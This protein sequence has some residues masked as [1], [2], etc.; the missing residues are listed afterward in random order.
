MPQ[1]RFCTILI[2]FQVA[3]SLARTPSPWGWKKK[4]S[5]KVV[6]TDFCVI[7]SNFGEKFSLSILKGLPFEPWG[8]FLLKVRAEV[9]TIFIF[10]SSKTRPFSF[11]IIFTFL[12]FKFLFFFRA[13]V[14]FT[15]SCLIFFFIF[16]L[17][18]KYIILKANCGLPSIFYF[19]F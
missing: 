5:P 11:F 2:N 3:R 19:F 6:S 14:C 1:E 15:S 18:I 17:I 4:N 7:L 10:Y 16:H 9:S 13:I 8:R 12:F